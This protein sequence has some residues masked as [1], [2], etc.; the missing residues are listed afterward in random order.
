[1]VKISVVVPIYKGDK[2]IKSIVRQVENNSIYFG[3]GEIELL[4]VNDYPD[5]IIQP[6]DSDKI[7]I[8]VFN[9]HKNRGIQGARIAGCGISTGK[10]IL[11]LD[12]D[13]LITDD[14]LKSQ[15]TNIMSC[16]ADVSICQAKE[17]GRLVYNSSNLFENVSDYSYILNNVNPIVSPGQVLIKKDAVSEIWGKNILEHNGA[18]DWLLWLCIHAENRKI[19]LNDRALYEHVVDGNN[20]SFNVCE[21]LMS[22]YDV[23]KVVKNQSVFSKREIEA[24]ENTIRSEQFR[25]IK[26]LEK[27]RDFFFLYD[28]WMRLENTD[29]NI[30][31]YLLRLG[32]KTV[33][34]YG[35]GYIGRQLVSKISDSVINVVGIIDKN[36]NYLDTEI[37]VQ[38][39]ENFSNTVDV[40]I[41]TAVMSDKQF[42]ILKNFSTNEV[43][44]IQQLLE[45]W[46]KST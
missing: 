12:Q 20:M 31:D 16:N 37:P 18:D 2:Y 41:V 44:T 19:V 38:T 23:L 11:F 10:Y 32:Y 25:H 1:M 42:N 26:I 43:I 21:M 5:H 35:Y 39:I 46:E 9:T 14:C 28:K 27:F 13:D 22:E 8:R 3:K 6:I 29:V 45:K 36:A 7:I 40:I 30:A 24:L 4:L 33:A 34:V 15:Y 17:N